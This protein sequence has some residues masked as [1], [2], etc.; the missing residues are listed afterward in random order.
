MVDACVS[1]HV[2]AERDLG[3]GPNVTLKPVEMWPQGVAQ[4][5]ARAEFF[6]RLVGLNLTASF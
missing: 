1:N 2:N 4:E 5:A 3:S 6:L